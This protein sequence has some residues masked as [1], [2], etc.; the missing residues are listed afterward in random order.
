MIGAII[1]DI[2]GS[3]FEFNNNKSK[4]FDMFDLEHHP[5]DDSLMTIAVAVAIMRYKNLLSKKKPASLYDEAVKAMRKLGAAYPEYM[6]MYGHGFREWLTSPDPKPYN[7]C[8]NGAAMRISP[9]GFAAKDI[10]EARMFAREITSPTHS[11]PEGLKGA[12]AV[13]VCIVLARDGKT[14]E[15]IR[16]YVNKNYYTLDFTID[17]IRPDYGFGALC[18]N[19]VPQAIEAFLE[20]ESFEDAI[21]TAVSLGGDSDTLAAIT[22]SVAEAF[23]GVPEDMREDAMDL[24]DDDDL[25][26]VIDMFEEKFQDEAD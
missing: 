16:D 2:A 22:G 11:H 26:D 3:A 13:A 14:K 9:A 21:R 12:E 19:T 1:G 10:E 24:L 8:G 23:Y 17:Q 4:K 15:E 20:S 6:S 7:S 18:Q 5:T 25:C